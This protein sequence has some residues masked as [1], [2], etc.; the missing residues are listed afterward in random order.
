[1]RPP[2]T[3]NKVKHHFS[4]HPEDLIEVIYRDMNPHAW[5]R[6]FDWIK[7]RIIHLNTQHG[8]I[9][10]GK[11]SFDAYISGEYSYIA[12]IRTGN[13]TELSLSIIDE[14]SLEIDIELEEIQS[15]QAFDTLLS[16]VKE[17]AGV[18]ACEN[19]IICPEFKP[20]QAFIINGNYL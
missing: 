12:T 5:K 4:G 14:N 10:P 6:L 16:N 19:Y 17:I 7:D 3:W 8:Y 11:L 2:M 1:M 18:I 9:E 20:E 13:E 15:A